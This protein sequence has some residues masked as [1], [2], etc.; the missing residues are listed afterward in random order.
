MAG[1][2]LGLQ[3]LT[4]GCDASA[5]T[6]APEVATLQTA[7][8]AT[9]AVPSPVTQE[10]PLIRPDDDPA[11][12]DRLTE[13]WTACLIRQGIP[14]TPQRPKVDLSDERYRDK[15]KACESKLPEPW[16]DRERRTNPHFEDLMRAEVKCLK[17]KGYDVTLG[18]DPLYP[19]YAGGPSESNRAFEDEQECQRQAFQESIEKY[20]G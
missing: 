5:D 8:A 19:M 14:I 4:T 16:L 6:A 12:V 15:A 1:L 17:D 20:K 18:G 9:S 7:S 11:T 2:A 10:R 3:L 13:V